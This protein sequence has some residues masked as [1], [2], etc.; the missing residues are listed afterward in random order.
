MRRL[1]FWVCIL[2]FT[3][4]VFCSAKDVKIH[5]FVTNVNSPTNFEIDD[6]RIMK[7]VSLQLDIEKDETGDSTATFKPVDIRVGD[8]GIKI[9]ELQAK[10]DVHERSL[11]TVG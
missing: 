2:L 3:S 4:A 8:V 7:D 1:T 11:Y 9:G 5:G 6:Y 10:S